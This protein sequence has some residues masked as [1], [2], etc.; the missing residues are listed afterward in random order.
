MS[1]GFE[2]I[3]MNLQLVNDLMEVHENG[4]LDSN[5]PLQRLMHTEEQTLGTQGQYYEEEGN[6]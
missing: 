5:T 1:K 6:R 2:H 4:I 3:W